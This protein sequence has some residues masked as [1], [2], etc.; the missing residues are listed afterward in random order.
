MHSLKHVKPTLFSCRFQPF[1]ILILEKW[2]YP[3]LITIWI[4][5]TGSTNGSSSPNTSTDKWYLQGLNNIGN[6]KAFQ[7]VC[8][9]TKY[10]SLTRLEQDCI[11]RQRVWIL[12]TT[13][14]GRLKPMHVVFLLCRNR[15]SCS[16]YYSIFGGS[17]GCPRQNMLYSTICHRFKS[18]LRVQARIGGTKSQQ[19]KWLSWDQYLIIKLIL[20]L[21]LVL[22]IYSKVNRNFH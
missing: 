2:D 21:K 22:F 6:L 13:F 16:A 10:R 1:A 4:K 9:V 12:K 11:R 18:H 8:L 15:I 3:Q 7:F 20:K 19:Q 5:R 14:R 17:V